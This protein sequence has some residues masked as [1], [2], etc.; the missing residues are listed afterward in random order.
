MAWPTC[1]Q[2]SPWL[3]E[4]SPLGWVLQ[5]Y[6]TSSLARKSVSSDLNPFCSF[7]NSHWQVWPT[8]VMPG[9]YVH[10]QRK[11]N[12]W[13]ILKPHSGSHCWNCA[14]TFGS[15]WR[16]QAVLWVESQKQNVLVL[17]PR[18]C[19]RTWLL[20]PRNCLLADVILPCKTNIFGFS[21]SEL[22]VR[23]G[24]DQRESTQAW[25]CQDNF[26]RNTPILTTKES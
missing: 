4:V 2:C 17:L 20:R 3:S 8:L 26:G 21:S 16:D 22:Q 11:R 5:P 9:M 1:S 6:L 18:S 23:E 10:S 14:N 12:P 19:L 13:Q 7:P 24:G 15:R 25:L